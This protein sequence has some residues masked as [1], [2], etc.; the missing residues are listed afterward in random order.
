MGAVGEARGGASVR[1]SLDDGPPDGGGLGDAG[2]PRGG[3]D[4]GEPAGSGEDARGVRAGLQDVPARGSGGDVRGYRGAAG[5]LEGSP[6]GATE[7]REGGG[8]AAVGIALGA[9]SSL[10]TALRKEQ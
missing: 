9:C 3:R 10:A 4:R 6:G 5:A 1:G 8:A 2:G 7:G